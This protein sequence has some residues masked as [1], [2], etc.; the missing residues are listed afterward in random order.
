MFPRREAERGHG[1][2]VFTADVQ[3]DPAGHEHLQPRTLGQ[4]ARDE[5]AR[6]RHLLEVVEHEQQ[7]LLPQV[8]PQD[9]EERL[10][11]GLPHRQRPRHRGGHR[12]AV[13]HRGQPHEVCAVGKVADQ[14]LRH[15]QRQAGLA[16][17]PWS[18]QAEQANLGA[19][20][21]LHDGAHLPL[22][23]HERGELHG[24]VVA[25][26][27]DG[28]GWRHLSAGDRLEGLPLLAGEPQCPGEQP[29]GGVAGHPVDA[30][31][32]VADR[33]HAQAGPLRQLLLAK[34]G[35]HPIPL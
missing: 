31:L 13:G 34:T 25:P 11:G 6:G 33:A 20:E 29:N 4:Q 1:V 26:R 2:R 7:I 30:P 27:G 22:A 19:Q 23:A 12:L 5:G 35:A 3:H 8:R 28:T 15:S 14:L 18:G 24:K 10:L 32:E 21:H 17:A 16:D 9:V